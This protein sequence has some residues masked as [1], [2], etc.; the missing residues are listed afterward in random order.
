MRNALILLAAFLVV[1]VFAVTSP[2]AAADDPPK[3]MP[4]IAMCSPL[5]AAPKTTSKV[6]IR[7]WKIESATEILC[8]VPHVAI[9]ILS[10]GAAAVPG[11]QDAKQIGDQQIEIEVTVGDVSGSATVHLTVV[12]PDGASQPHTLL[13]GSPLSMSADLEPNDG[14]RQAQ[15]I[16]LPQTVDGLIHADGNVDAFAIDVDQPNQVAFEVNA[17][18]LGSGLDSIL[19]LYDARFNIVA[20]NDD[21]A[22]S[23]DSFLNVGLH[24]GRYYIVLQDAHDHGGPAHPYRLTI[25]TVPL[26][27]PETSTAADGKF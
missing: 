3:E 14:F 2:E 20:D 23:A 15:I 27:S 12:S 17:R 19:T 16:Q 18:K 9:R 1:A 13:I 25:S 24:Q 4:R 5:F 22:E 8:D 26:V 11:K 7:G 10:K 21:H 6:V